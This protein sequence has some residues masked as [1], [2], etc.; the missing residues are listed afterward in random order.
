[1]RWACSRYE[2]VGFRVVD[3]DAGVGAAGEGFGHGFQFAGQGD[4]PGV[5]GKG[6][7]G[8]LAAEFVGQGLNLLH[9]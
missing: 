7:G 3:G 9:R 1:M 6:F 5:G 4:E 8:G 2:V